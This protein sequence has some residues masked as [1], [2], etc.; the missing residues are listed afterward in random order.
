MFAPEASSAVNESAEPELIIGASAVAIDGRAILIEGP[1]GSGKSSLC[2]ALIETGA[3]LIG[4]DGALVSRRDDLVIIGP[5]PRAT[6][7]I[8][9]RGIGLASMAVAEPCRL[10]L[11]LSIVDTTEAE[12]QTLPERLPEQAPVREVLGCPIPCSP[13]IPGAIAPAAR[14]RWALKLHGLA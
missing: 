9:V 3:Q 6:G 12:P 11:I 8:E 5:P 13:F 14:A 2:L 4:D 10:S 1:P 7:L